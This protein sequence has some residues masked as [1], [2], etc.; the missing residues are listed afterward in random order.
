MKLVSGFWFTFRYCI[1]FCLLVIL[2]DCTVE[3]DFFLLC[4]HQVPYSDDLRQFQ[5]A[6]LWNDTTR[7]SGDQLEAMDQ[8]IDSMMLPSESGNDVNSDKIINPHQQ[9]L[10]NCL[11]QRA[12]N[13]S[14]GV[15]AINKANMYL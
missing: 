13:P 11:T 4:V 6:P 12:L 14:K 8:L 9:Y 15:I 1:S 5:F 3:F 2:F 10:Y 7:P